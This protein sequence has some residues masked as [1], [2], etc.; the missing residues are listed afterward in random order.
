L[1][2]YF[3]SESIDFCEWQANS[4]IIEWA[5]MLSWTQNREYAVSQ[6]SDL[7]QKLAKAQTSVTSTRAPPPSLPK[8]KE[9]KLGLSSL[10]VC[11]HLIV[12]HILRNIVIV[13]G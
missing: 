10:K 3:E 8:D 4:A 12:F 5:L 11:I 13:E 6:L 9:D 1:G 7:H 2:Q